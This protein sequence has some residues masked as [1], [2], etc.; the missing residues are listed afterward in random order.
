[1][2]KVLR[3]LKL[4]LNIKPQKVRTESNPTKVKSNKPGTKKLENGEFF[5]K[6]LFICTNAPSDLSISRNPPTQALIP[7]NKC[8]K[9]SI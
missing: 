5:K 6:S 9:Y 8:K 2:F 7:R 1:M 4:N 3:I